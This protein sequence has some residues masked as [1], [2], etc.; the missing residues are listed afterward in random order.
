[1][2]DT[3]LIPYSSEKLN[4]QLRP[5]MTNCLTPSISKITVVGGLFDKNYNLYSDDVI[6]IKRA[7]Y[8]LQRAGVTISKNPHFD[9]YNLLA[10]LRNDFLRTAW[11]SEPRIQTD[12]IITCGIWGGQSTQMLI[13]C[14]A[15][16][17][18]EEAYEDFNQLYRDT[19]KG[20]RDN[21]ELSISDFQCGEDGWPLAAHWSGAKVVVTRGPDHDL[22]A[23]GSNHFLPGEFY[24]A[25]M[26]TKE[27]FET[28]YGSIGGPL[29][30]VVHKD[31]IAELKKTAVKKDILGKRILAL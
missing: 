31:A 25:A 23:V 21:R 17:Q 18:Q 7:I 28:V 1:M 6:T 22:D 8:V 19:S 9:F 13:H 30:I 15:R 5:E 10:P 12:L 20:F 3:E 26:A 2:C 14:F 16:Q 24:R 4:E 29:G 27:K 11:V